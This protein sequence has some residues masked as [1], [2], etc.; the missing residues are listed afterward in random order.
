MTWILLSSLTQLCK[1]T[2]P[3]LFSLP[4]LV[5][6]LRRVYAAILRAR[7]VLIK[8]EWRRLIGILL[9]F[10]LRYL[11]I[12]LMHLS[13]LLIRQFWR[14]SGYLTPSH[15]LLVLLNHIQIHTTTWDILRYISRDAVLDC[16]SWTLLKMYI[17]STFDYLWQDVRVLCCTSSSTPCAPNPLLPRGWPNILVFCQLIIIS[18]KATVRD[19]LIDLSLRWVLVE[20][21]SKGWILGLLLLVW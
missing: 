1:N 5:R 13:L 2:R 3:E 9:V 6:I 15:F 19:L 14:R 7:L 8:V 4:R 10:L 18:L 16:G 20:C 11:I 12:L 21:A 17:P